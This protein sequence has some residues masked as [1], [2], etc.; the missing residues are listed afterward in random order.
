MLLHLKLRIGAILI[1]VG[2]LIAVLGEILNFWNNDPTAGGW[3]FTTG[4]VVLGVLILVYGINLYIQLS[5]KINLLGLIGGG[6]LFLGGLLTIVGTIAVDMVVI[7]MLLGIA[8]T[9]SAIV[10]APGAAAQSATNT[11]SSGLNTLKNGAAG[12]FGQ[13]GGS[14]IPAV[15]V[16]SV[17]GLDIVNKTLVGLHLPSF[18]GISQWGHFFFSGGALAIGGLI[19]GYALLR[20]KVFSSTTCL[21]IMVTAGLNL[22]SQI[23]FIPP[24]IANLTGILLFA[25]LAWLGA[26][27]LFPTTIGN[28]VFHLPSILQ[29]KR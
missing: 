16:P 5:D 11:V 6:L 29:A 19:L 26:S 14:N 25:G 12:L 9:I 27:I 22:I 10:N 23:P 2:G 18:A 21:I 1:L 4:L 3:F 13:G 28:R 8:A 20:A 15:T 7:P 17:N 24:F